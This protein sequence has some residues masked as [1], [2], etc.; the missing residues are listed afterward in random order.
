M[1]T[2]SKILSS[3]KYTKLTLL[4]LLL[5]AVSSCGGKDKFVK[6]PIDDIVRDMPTDR[7]F[8]VILY[9]M[10]V[11]GNFF[12][13]FYHKYRIIEETTPGQPEER[14]TDWVEVPE[15]YFQQHVDDM[16]M[17]LV[18]RGEDGQVV[19]SVSPPGYN[20]YV[21]N[22]QYG[23]WVQR[24]GGSFWEFYGKYAFISSMFNM[25]TYPARRSYYDDYRGN[26]YGRGRSYYGPRTSSGGS[27]YGTNS[28]Y[29][30]SSRPN[31]TW[32]SNRSTF[33]DRVN[34]RT[35]RSSSTTSSSR[36]SRSSSRYRGTSSRSRGGGFGK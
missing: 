27:Y 18:H 33:K 31:S 10:N 25:F 4:T 12:E 36:T 17:E 6:N 20:N 21:G 35:S 28:T 5:I 34:R 23:Q 19:K 32:S 9:D 24:D 1:R 30:R 15:R 13:D 11:E 22:P 8:S 7:I 26:Y 3:M 2:E 14:I 29:N 16:G